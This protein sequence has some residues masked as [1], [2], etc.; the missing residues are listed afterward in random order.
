[1]RL[2]FRGIPRCGEARG[3]CLIRAKA[4]SLM[5]YSEPA[6]QES[7]SGPIRVFND[8]HVDFEWFIKLKPG[9]HSISLEGINT[10]TRYPI[11]IQDWMMDV[12]Y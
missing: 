6:P 1:M 3:E 10:D 8:V 4:D 5:M 2:N 12:Q 7:T 11:A 9:H